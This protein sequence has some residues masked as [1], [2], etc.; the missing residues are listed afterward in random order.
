MEEIYKNIKGHE[1]YS[2]SNFGNVRNNKN[3]NILKAPLDKYGYQRLRING[4]M[5]RVH[6]LVAET[7]IPNQDN[8]KCVDHIDNDRTNNNVNNL[9]FV[10]HQEN[11]FNKSISKNNS[12][13]TKGIS[14]YKPTNKWVAHIMYNKKQYNLGYFDKLEDAILARQKKANEI[15][16]EFTHSSERIVNLN[17]EIPKNTQLNINIKVKED[18]EYKK[19]E[20]EFEE[21]IK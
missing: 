10:T 9:R 17:I 20:Q 2:V 1:N 13:G 5:F 18:E 3:G 16:G 11:S 8:K 14:Y 6:R 15:Y 12:S 7:F 21:L 19:L 4:K